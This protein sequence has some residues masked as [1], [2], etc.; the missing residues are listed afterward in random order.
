MK[1][2]IL[3]SGFG[4]LKDQF[5]VKQCIDYSEFTNEIIHT[6]DGHEK[7]LYLVSYKQKDFIIFSGKLHI[8]EG[9]CQEDIDAFYKNVFRQFPA[10]AILI[11]S[12]SG[13]LNASCKIGTWY[14]LTSIVNMISHGKEEILESAKASFSKSVQMGLIEKVYAYQEGPSTGT[15]AEY[16]ALGLLNADIVGMSMLPEFKSLSSLHIP[17]DFI[18]LPVCNYFPFETAQEPAFTEILKVSEMS[19]AELFKLVEIFIES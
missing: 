16:Q 17:C 9:Y 15:K 6:L 14:S 13:A 18:S 8:Y 10:D 5:I 3:G 7:K 12:A 11:T 4:K 2:V 19:I 1:A